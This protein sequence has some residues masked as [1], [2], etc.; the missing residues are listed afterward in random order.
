MLTNIVV[1]SLLFRFRVYLQGGLFEA[2][3]SPPTGW[4]HIILNYLGPSNGEGIRIY[5]DGAE[6]ASDTTKVHNHSQLETVE[7]FWA[8]ST[9]TGTNDMEVCK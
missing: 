6:V 5:Y 2:T 7:L 8:D 3:R 1:K 4:T 9:Q